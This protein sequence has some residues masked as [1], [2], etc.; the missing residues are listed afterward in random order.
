LPF[1]IGG[2]GHARRSDG[3][4]FAD[5]KGKH[6]KDSCT[7][8]YSRGKQSLEDLQWQ[9]LACVLENWLGMVEREDWRID[10]NGVVGDVETWKEADMAWGWEKCVIPCEKLSYHDWEFV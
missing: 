3:Q 9:S 2:N 4:K 5:D 6:G 8:L 10:E 1:A 7:E